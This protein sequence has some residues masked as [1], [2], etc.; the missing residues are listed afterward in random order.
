MGALVAATS[1]T[2]ISAILILFEITQ[3]IEIIRR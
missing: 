1:Q 3:R 2:P